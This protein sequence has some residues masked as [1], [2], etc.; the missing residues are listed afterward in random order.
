[1]SLINRRLMA[2]ISFH[3]TIH[4]FRAGRR[5]GTAALDAKLLQQIT[6][7]REAVLFE[8]FLDLRKAYVSLE[9]ERELRLLAAYGVG[10]RMVRLIRAYWNLP[11]MM[12]KAVGYFGRP[13][14]GYRGVMQGDP[15]SSTIFNVVVDAVI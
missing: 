11:T 13:F 4:G 3:D 5:R 8:V 6:S 2:E 1:M 15:L 12:A 7:M 14:K 9:R 10:P